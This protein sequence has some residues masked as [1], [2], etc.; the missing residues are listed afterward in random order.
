MC[1]KTF[2]ALACA[3]ISAP[4]FAQT[5]PP[6]PRELT[7]RQEPCTYLTPPSYKPSSYIP[8]Y[9]PPSDFGIDRRPEYEKHWRDPPAPASPSDDLKKRLKCKHPT[10]GSNSVGWEQC[11]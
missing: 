3:A 11:Y 7:R 10:F 9:K 1:R 6:C 4:A 5:L 2:I 8:P